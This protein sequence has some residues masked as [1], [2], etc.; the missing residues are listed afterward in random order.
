MSGSRYFLHVPGFTRLVGPCLSTA[1]SCPTIALRGI[2]WII[3]RRRNE[4][5]LCHPKRHW[6]LPLLLLQPHRLLP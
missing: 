2:M 4:P 1:K 6:L 3:Q 5:R